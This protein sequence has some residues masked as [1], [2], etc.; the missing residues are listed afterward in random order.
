VSE[1]NVGL[2]AEGIDAYNRGD[3]DGLLNTYAPDVECV[4]DARALT[5]PM[6]GRDAV[7]A[8]LED[9]AAS[10]EEGTVRWT[11]LELFEVD[12]GRVV[13]GGEWG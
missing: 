7:R 2:V 6:R 10:F 12:D 1:E 3:L 9:L 11:T 5:A 13:H 4:T 8:W